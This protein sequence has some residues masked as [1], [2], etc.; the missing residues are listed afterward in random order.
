MYQHIE[1]LRSRRHEKVALLLTVENFAGLLFVAFPVY[2]STTGL[3]PY[4][5][6]MLVTI[7][8]GVV[9]IGVTLDLGGLALYER[10]IWQIRGLIRRG[11]QG[12]RIRPPD[13][14]G[15]ALELRARPL[16]NDGP[17]KPWTE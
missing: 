4:W 10:L 2:L 8:A 5:L 1:E 15:T 7:I 3:E 13:L 11:L 12:D 6:R 9:G 16:A 17:I 14:P